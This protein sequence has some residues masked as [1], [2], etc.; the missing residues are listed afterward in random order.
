MKWRSLLIQK[1][2]SQRLRVLRDY[3]CTS[4]TT[5]RI[6][7]VDYDRLHESRTEEAKADVLA[8]VIDSGK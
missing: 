1:M 6:I 7:W 8:F 5:S 3:S 2:V 4:T